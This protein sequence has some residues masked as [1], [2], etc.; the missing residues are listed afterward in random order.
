M[1][2]A[3]LWICQ[4]NSGW[5]VFKR[6]LSILPS[7]VSPGSAPV[8]FSPFSFSFFNTIAPSGRAGADE[9]LLDATLR[10][11]E[12]IDQTLDSDDMINGREQL[13]NLIK[14]LRDR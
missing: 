4:R 10:E 9:M 1:L 13:K 2:L 8:T 5:K 7:H 14:R 12:A 3:S 11:L 6:L